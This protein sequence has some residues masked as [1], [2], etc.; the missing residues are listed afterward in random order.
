MTANQRNDSPQHPQRQTMP[1]AWRSEEARRREIAVA[2]YFLCSY[3]EKLSSATI[4]SQDFV[5]LPEI[6]M[7]WDQ[8]LSFEAEGRSWAYLDAT[9][10]HGAFTSTGAETSMGDIV[11]DAGLTCM[12][13]QMPLFQ[14]Q[15]REARMLRSVA[16]ELRNALED[17][18][19]GATTDDVS[20]RLD[21]MLGVLREHNTEGWI[22]LGEASKQVAREYCEAL[23]SGVPLTIPMPLQGLQDELDGFPLGTVVMIH[24]ITSGHKTTLARMAAEHAA[25]LKTKAAYLSLEDS[26]QH[27]AAR[28][29]SSRSGG[30]FTVRDLLTAKK[31]E[32]ITAGIIEAADEAAKRDVPLWIR[33]E[34]M[35]VTK[36]VARIYEAASKGCK[37]VAIDFFQLLEPDGKTGDWTQ[38]WMAAANAIRNAARKTGVCVVLCVQPT[39][40]ATRK[41]E[42]LG[43]LLGL[44]DIRGGSSINQ[45][46]FGLL[47]LAFE[48]TESGQ[49]VPGVIKISVTKW[50]TGTP[51]ALL[52]FDLD[53]AY[54]L[55][56]DPP[57]GQPSP[58][59]EPPSKALRTP[60]PAFGE[61]YG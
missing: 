47:T 21:R 55:I 4:T 49:R 38:F 17:I 23:A 3:P 14:R 10:G 22:R 50:K 57:G 36:C 6:G 16:L 52:T 29:M 20:G 37:L 61:G 13:H 34:G 7:W 11:M 30:A 56:S 27:I 33:H 35:T 15:M 46:A 32:E 24:A 31:G 43:R 51:G 8:A 42:E 40:D 58:G 25:N 39:Q 26:P 60:R 54:D 53:A 44:G 1:P 19:G 9:H 5:A 45:A 18:D 12:P 2:N 28:S 48:Y 59:G 41:A